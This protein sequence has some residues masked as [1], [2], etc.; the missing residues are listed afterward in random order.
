MWILILK[1]IMVFIKDTSFYI[2]NFSTNN[3]YN[4]D[5]RTAMTNF[6][7]KKNIQSILISAVFIIP[8]IFIPGLRDVFSLPKFVCLILITLGLSIFIIYGFISGKIDKFDNISL[9]PVILFVSSCIL[10]TI[11]S[12]NKIISIYGN[13][14]YRQESLIS[15]ICYSI[16]FLSVFLFSTRNH[17]HNLITIII[18]TAFII[19]LYAIFQYFGLFVPKSKDFIFSTLG[20]PS[21]LGNFISAILPLSIV[22]ALMNN[23][24]FSDKKFIIY[25]G[26]SIFSL[27]I[28]TISKSRTAILSTIFTIFFI[29]VFF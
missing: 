7:V 3:H 15:N 1:E 22:L 11:F 12:S 13:Y 19:N 5:R 27:I 29:M 9:L 6:D 20:N 23:T 10:S 4:S 24:R 18:W 17:I 26:L 16:I 21:F 25:F 28:I 14:L 2:N 8:L